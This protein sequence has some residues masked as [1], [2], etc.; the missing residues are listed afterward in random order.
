MWQFREHFRASLAAG[1]DDEVMP[2]A[3]EDFRKREIEAASRFRPGLHRNT[4]TGAARLAAIDRDDENILPPRLIRRIDKL[5]AEENLVLNGNGVQFAGAHA[6]KSQL[7]REGLFREH[8]KTIRRAPRAKEPLLRREEK[9]LPRMRPNDVTEK[10]VV[11]AFLQAISS[12][13]LLIGPTG[14]KLFRAG[15]RVVN[16]RAIAQG[17]PDDLIAARLQRRKQTRQLR[18]FQRSLVRHDSV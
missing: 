2:P 11:A 18:S 6:K 8:L 3:L 15:Q 1:L 14:G 16:N 4:K 5:S 7:G 9:L 17:R 10:R 12:A 13:V